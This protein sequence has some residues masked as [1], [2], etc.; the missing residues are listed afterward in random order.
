MGERL[1]TV[2]H[3][4]H[5]GVD[6][7]GGIGTVLEGLLTSPVYQRSV[8]RSIIVGPLWNTGAQADAKA[9]LGA[10]GARVMYS[11]LDGVDPDGLGARLKP[12]EWAFGTRLVYGVR[13]FESQSDGGRSGEA[14]LLLFDLHAPNH[15][16]MDSFKGLLRDRLGID[17]SRYDHDGDFVQW[18]RL[19]PPAIAALHA[20]LKDEEFPVVVISHEYMGMCT[21]LLA[22][23]DVK[24]RFRT[25]FHAHECST[26]RRVVEDHPGHDCAFYPVMRRAIAEGKHLEDLFG[27]RSANPRHVLISNAHRLDMTLA[28][29]DE[30]ANELRFLSDA[31]ARSRIELCYNGVPAARLNAAAVERS[32]TL[33]W[34]WMDRA[35][36][37]KPDYLFT[38]VTRPVISKGLWRDLRVCAHLERDLKAKGRSAVSLLLTCGAPVRSRA[39]VDDMARRY[40]WPSE[41]HEG[42]P[43]LA[44]P[45]IGFW[46]D[47]QVFNNPARPGAGAI[48]AVLV[49]QFGFSAERVGGAAPDELTIG[50]LRRAA[51]VEF[52]QSIYEPFG[53][54]QLEPLHAGAICVPSSVCGCVGF[55]RRAIEEV[56]RT[57]AATP[58]LLV[59]DYTDVDVPDPLHMTQ[60]QRDAIEERVAERVSKEL[61]S[62]LPTSVADRARL[63]EVGQALAERMGWDRVCEHDFLPALRSILK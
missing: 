16:R 60:A 25:V 10:Y 41:H 47:I 57:E 28:V 49:N 4:T 3:V 24:R 14:E 63:L 27:D 33:V 61:V 8:R 44:G 36:G 38:H 26:A 15:Q 9:R 52:G 54:A 58:N 12:V 48:K 62:R 59:A 40:D 1:M 56:G 23:Q 19:A 22:A 45:E 53:I 50:D 18:M 43:D 32:R 51:D 55:A 35:L 21:A 11:G 30:T 17:A 7:L 39:Q 46:R 42:Y 13:R 2:V 20:V 31:L 6:H 37:L 5:E 34:R 29:G